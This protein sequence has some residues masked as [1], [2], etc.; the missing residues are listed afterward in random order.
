V[1]AIVAQGVEAG[2]HRGIFLSED[3][4]TQVGTMALVPQMVRRVSVP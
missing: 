2:G 4:T 1:D 3:V